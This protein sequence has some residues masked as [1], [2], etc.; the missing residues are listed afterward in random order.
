[1]L[2]FVDSFDHYST[3]QGTR[4]WS[5]F[6]LSF[7]GIGATGRHGS[8]G[9]RIGI[10]TGGLSKT[11]DAQQTWITGFAFK[12]SSLANFPLASFADSGVPQCSVYVTSAGTIKAY[13]W[14]ESGVLLG[15]SAAVIS[16]AAFYYIEVKAK[17][18]SSTGTIDVHV[19]GI[20]VLSLSG[21]NTQNSGNATADS[22]G[23]GN[24]T[25]GLVDMDYDDLYICD[26]TGSANNDFLGDIRIDATFPNAEGSTIEWTPS[27]GT[28]NSAL[29][30]DNPSN[31]DSNYD[32]SSTPGQIDFYDFPNITPT[33]GTVY[34]VV[35][36]MTVRKDDAGSRTFR[37]KIF[38]GSTEYDGSTVGAGDTYGIF[39]EIHEEDPD[40]SSPWT[41]SGV[42]AAQ[43]GLELVS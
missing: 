35:L 28:D 20:S 17:I 36:Q 6:N 43:F 32:S 37:G 19:N 34:G 4:K 25:G 42:N 11:L 5:V 1:M 13:R 18:H 22:V 8:N 12:M 30:S 27:T 3:A 26:S 40:T 39:S 31:D 14:T 23:F 29:V 7:G 9:A 24:G 15:T 41:I 21:V 33:S 10:L 16:P 2:R 38:Q